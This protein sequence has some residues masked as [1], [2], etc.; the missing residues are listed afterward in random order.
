M[1]MQL[2]CAANRA[3]KLE[4]A[5]LMSVPVLALLRVVAEEASSRAGPERLTLGDIRSAASTHIADPDFEIHHLARIFHCTARTIQSRFAQSGETFSRWQLRERLELAR[6]RLQAREFSGR[7]VETVA[8]SC[9]FRDGSHFNRAF[10]A[11]FGAPPG[12][13]RS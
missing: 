4:L 13:L 2:M 10:K 9:G 7:S 1:Q 8:Y 6:L 3:G 11:H 5:D 12:Q